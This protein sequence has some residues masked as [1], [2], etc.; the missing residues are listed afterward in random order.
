VRQYENREGCLVF[1]DTIGEKAYMDENE[2]VCWYYDHRK[3]RNV[4][5]VT[6]LTAFYTAGNE[7][8]KLQTPIDYQIIS[9]TETETE[10]KTGKERRKSENSKNEMMREMINRTIQ[11]HVRFGYIVADSWFASK[12]NMRYIQ[13]K[14]KGFIFEINGNRLAA[15]SEREREQGR[16]VRIARMEIV[17]EEPIP[18][19]LKDLRFQVIFYKQVFK[20]REG[21]AGVWYL[22]TNDETMSG[23]QL[24]SLYK[25]GWSVEVY[26]ESIKQNT[27]IGSSPAHTGRTQGNHIIAS[28]YAYVKLGLVRLNHGYNQFTVKSQIYKVSLKMLIELL[29]SFNMGDNGVFA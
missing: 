26:H 6:I 29:S 17:D 1:D 12:E 24:K 22:V 13:K 10:A 2:I 14:G 18:V 16:F 7:Y 5:G 20:N 11:R 21:S 28:I 4:K 8:G 15:A 19:Y 9:K 27:S 23:D 25:K 3:G